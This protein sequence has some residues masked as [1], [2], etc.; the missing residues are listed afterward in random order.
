VIDTQVKDT[1]FHQFETQGTAVPDDDDDDND[2]DFGIPPPP[3]PPR[4][5]DHEARSSSAAPATLLPLTLL[6]LRSSR[7]LLSSRLIWQPSRP[8][9]QRFNSRCLRECYLCFRL[10][11]T[12]RILCS[13]GG[14]LSIA[15]CC[16]SNTLI[17]PEKRSTVKKI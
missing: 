2:D 1:A 14:G 17:Q 10:F 9:K 5:H 7:P 6:L 8:V 12:D 3:P 13:R 15:R 11:R 16:S 4:S